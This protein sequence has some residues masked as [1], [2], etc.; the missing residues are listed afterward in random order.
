MNVIALLALAVACISLTW[1]IAQWWI[2]RRTIVELETAVLDSVGA[3]ATYPG[4]LFLAT[5][6]NKSH[7]E[8]HVKSATLESVDSD[9]SQLAALCTLPRSEPTFPKSLLPRDRTTIF[10]DVGLLA[11]GFDVSKPF[12][13][14]ISLGDG[15]KVK[16]EI[17][18]G[19]SV[20]R[21]SESIQPI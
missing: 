9:L 8:V 13:L 19:I 5:L 17:V 16:S 3:D 4:P 15:R 12:V 18:P 1:Q 11:Q 7:H 6:T 21:P 2:D 10:F 20:G 14:E